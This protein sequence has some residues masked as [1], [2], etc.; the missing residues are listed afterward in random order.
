MRELGKLHA[1]SRARAEELRQLEEERLDRMQAGIWSTA[2][3]GHLGSI[4]RVLKIMD[5]RARLLG[6][7]AP[8]KQSQTTPDGDQPYDPLAPL[9]EFDALLIRMGERLG[10]DAVP[11]G[12]AR[13]AAD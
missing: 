7:Y 12:E 5:L 2:I 9:R 11:S 13:D 1:I 4:D 6:L 10:S 8:V 3:Q